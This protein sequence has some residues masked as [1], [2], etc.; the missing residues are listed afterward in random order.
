M[1]Q[2]ALPSP[3]TQTIQGMAAVKENSN[4]Y[5]REQY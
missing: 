5:E 4:S 1:D 3:S 2:A